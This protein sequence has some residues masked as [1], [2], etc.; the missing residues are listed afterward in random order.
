MSAG[1]FKM[2]C[3][4]VGPLLVFLACDE[5]TAEERAALEAHL[6]GCRDCRELLSEEGQFQ[7]SVSVIP[8][9]ADEMDRS[10]TLLARF[11]A[12]NCSNGFRQMARES[13][14]WR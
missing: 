7:E 3:G 2:N 8:Q 4:D 1:D 12:C 11:S 13:R 5:V 14:A 6:A 9:A 10:G